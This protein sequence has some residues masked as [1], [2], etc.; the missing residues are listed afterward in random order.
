MCGIAG[1]Q[2]NYDEAR[3]RAM[4]RLMHHRGPDDAGHLMLSSA[5]AHVGLGHRRLSIIDLGAGR[6]PMTNEDGSLHVVFNGEIYNYQT[7]Q[8]RLVQAGHHFATNCDTEVLLHG[9]EEF[10]GALVEHLEGMFAFALWDVKDRSWF[11]ARDRFG[12]KPLYYCEPRLGEL[13]FASEIKPLLPFVGGPQLNLEGL[14]HFLLHGWVPTTETIFRGIHQLRPAHCMRWKAGRRDRRRYWRLERTGETHSE[15]EWAEILRLRLDETVRSHLIA[16]VPVG[17]TLS[18]GLDSSAVLAFM[19]RTA[20]PADIQ[21]FTVGYGLP[22]DE[23][24]YARLAAHHMGVTNHERIV[25]IERIASVFARMLW[26]LE[27]PMA[28]P[29]MGTSWFLSEFVRE[30][31][32]VALI[33]EGSDELFAGYPHFKLFAAPYSWAPRWLTMRVLPG[34]AFVMPSAAQAAE[35]LHP[36]LLDRPLLESVAHAFDSYVEKESLGDGWLRCELEHELVYSQLAR[37]DKLTMAHSV[38]ARVPF[39]DRAFAE[40]A[41]NIPFD[42]KVRGGSQKHILRQAVAPLLPHDIVYRPKTGP[43]GT[44][45]LLPYLMEH[46]L[47][48][49]IRELTS[50]EAIERRGWFRPDAVQN[51]LAQADSWWVRHHPIE[52][53]RRLKFAFALATLE[54]WARMFIDGVAVGNAVPKAA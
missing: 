19:A 9:Y 20:N 1:F 12:I 13:A 23:T 21:A 43:K 24:P 45:A 22:N 51:Y 30:H 10:G 14:Y 33:G 37:I 41:F 50:A 47:K 26:H 46:V 54:Q 49:Q 16:D 32:K 4:T 40:T 42:M 8:A 27:E 48:G 2:G 35:L 44:Q 18:G 34:A 7:L 53:R 52:G 3:L 31:V 38:E 29:V 39:L 5:E 15:A 36:D 6:Q 25:P 11:L 28:H 17:I